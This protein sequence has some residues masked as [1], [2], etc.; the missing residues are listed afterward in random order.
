MDKQEEDIAE[1]EDYA[2]GE[3]IPVIDNSPEL[4]KP[5]L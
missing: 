2:E 4:E 3:L 1:E 5:E